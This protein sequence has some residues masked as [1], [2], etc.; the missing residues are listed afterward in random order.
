MIRAPARGG[1]RL[2][3]GA[4]GRAVAAAKTWRNNWR[5]QKARRKQ[6][7]RALRKPCLVCPDLVAKG[8][9]GDIP[10]P[11][12]AMTKLFEPTLCEIRRRPLEKTGAGEWQPS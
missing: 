12:R 11:P 3:E 7:G 1:S 5:K 6:K 10:T 9:S 2:V 8:Y 4:H